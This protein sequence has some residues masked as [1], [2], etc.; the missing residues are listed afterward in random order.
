MSGPS[1]TCPMSFTRIGVPFSLAATTTRSRYRRPT[2]HSRG[3]AP[4]IRRRPARSCGRRFRCC[5]RGSASI[6]LLIGDVVGLEPVR[7]DIHLV[8]LAESADGRDFRHAGHG[9]QVIAQ[10]PVLQRPQVRQAVLARLVLQHVLVDPAEAGGVRPQFGLG[11]LRQG[12]QGT[13]ER[14]SSVRVRAQ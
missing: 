9:L 10:I 13:P 12:R 4:C 6:T 5:C 14:Y 11:T 8:L 7:I 2:S 1:A 3:R